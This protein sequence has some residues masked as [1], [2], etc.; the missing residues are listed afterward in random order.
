VKT[1]K[2]CTQT[3]PLGEFYFNKKQGTSQSYCKPC[4]VAKSTAWGQKNRSRMRELRKAWDKKNPGYNK[5][6][7]QRPRRRDWELRRTYGI[8]LKEYENLFSAQGKC[9]AI[10][11]TTSPGKQDSHPWHTD[12]CHKNGRVRGILCYNCN[13]ALGLVKD[14]PIILRRMIAYLKK[15]HKKNILDNFPLELFENTSKNLDS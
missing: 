1:C 2:I 10:C 5:Q 3:K 9:C 8:T 14:S 4:A 11:K 15:E 12:H 6:Y 7:L 13:I